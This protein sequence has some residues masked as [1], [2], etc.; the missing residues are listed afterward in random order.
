M[1][2]TEHL[3]VLVKK[4]PRVTLVLQGHVDCQY[5][6]F[7][8]IQFSI[9]FMLCIFNCHLNRELEE[10]K[11]S[12][13]YLVSLVTMAEQELMDNGE[14]RALLVLVVKVVHRVY[15]V[16]MEP[17][18]PKVISV[19]REPKESRE[20][21][22]M[23]V[24]MDKMENKDQLYACLNIY[25]SGTFTK[26]NLLTGRERKPWRHRNCWTTCKTLY[27]YYCVS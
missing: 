20:T 4:D 16:F 27:Q 13:E 7:L 14:H 6:F 10:D 18:D 22:E 23:M 24:I 17:K 2:M 9:P 1:E 8:I 12:R 11:E 15:L 21:K 25:C 5:A 26:K 3:V 19:S